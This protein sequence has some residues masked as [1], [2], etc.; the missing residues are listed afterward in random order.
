MKMTHIIVFVLLVAIA[1]VASNDPS[2]YEKGNNSTEYEPE[3]ESRA[4]GHRCTDDEQ[5]LSAIC[6]SLPFHIG[7]SSTRRPFPVTRGTCCLDRAGPECVLCQAGTGECL[8]CGKGTVRRRGGCWKRCSKRNT[9]C[10]FG[11]KCIRGACIFPRPG[12]GE[13]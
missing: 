12:K 11:K 8:A 6:R 2:E 13:T 9:H 7:L 1:V 5:C 4:P 3:G 10:S